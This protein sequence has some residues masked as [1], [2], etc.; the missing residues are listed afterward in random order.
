MSDPI[1]SDPLDQGLTQLLRSAHVPEPP[2]DL[3]AR[4]LAPVAARAGARRRQRHVGLAIAASLFVGLAVGVFLRTGVGPSQPGVD[5]E[6]VI[7]AGVISTVA[8]EFNAGHPV[9]GAVFELNIPPGFELAGHEGKRQLRWSGDLK[10]G[11]NR[12]KLRLSG[13][14]G[15]AGPLVASVRANAAGQPK[16]YTTMLR[17]AAD[18]SRAASGIG[19]G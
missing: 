13:K 9:Q 4:L 16:T 5:E 11:R 7:R 14:P 10:Q 19:S 17:A 18:E 1:D 3:A 8:V 15:S 6:V 2:E 12:L